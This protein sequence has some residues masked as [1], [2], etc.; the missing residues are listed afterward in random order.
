M[1]ENECHVTYGDLNLGFHQMLFYWISLSWWKHA[2]AE[3][4]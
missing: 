4:F 1:Q 3:A 2:K